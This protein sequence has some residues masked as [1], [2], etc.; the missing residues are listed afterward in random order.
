MITFISWKEFKE[1][2]NINK[3]YYCSNF[4]DAN[5]NKYGVKYGTSLRLFQW[6]QNVS[7]NS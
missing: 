6:V 5:L 3:R 7:N 1:L 4:Y 2:K